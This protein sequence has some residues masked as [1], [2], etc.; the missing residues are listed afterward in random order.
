MSIL[1]SKEKL[2][3]VILDPREKT[4]M[5]PNNKRT[6]LFIIVLQILLG[7][8]QPIL[9]E[10]WPTRL[11]DKHRSGVT[12]ES[13]TVPLT[14][15]WTYKTSTQPE[16]AWTESPA[17]HDYYHLWY[18]LKPRQSFDFSFDVA[19]ADNR[20]YFGS[21][22]TGEVT[23]LNAATGMEDWTF[24]TEGPV[25][26]CPHFDNGK[27]FI[28]S[29]DGYAYCLNASDGSLVWSERAGPTD[30]MIWGNEHMISVWPVRGSVM[31]DGADVFWTVGI[32][33]QEG[34][35]V[36]KRNASDGTGGWAVNASL[37]PQGY[38]L[39][40]AANLF[41]PTGKTYPTVYS[42]SS[43]SYVGTV[44][45]NTR[46]GGSWALL[47]PDESEFWTGPSVTNTTN[48]FNASS[49]AHIASVSGANYL[50]ADSTHSWYNTDSKI[51]K[52]KRSDRSVVWAI[53][54]AYPHALIKAGDTVFAGGFKEIAAFDTDGTRIWTAQ[55]DGKVYG[56]A[57]ANGSLYASTDRG[58][59][60]C[61]NSTIPQIT[62]NQG[63]TDVTTGSAALNGYLESQGGSETT[64]RV[65]WG[66]SD[67]GTNIGI[68]QNSR[69]LGVKSPGPISIDA[70]SL[71][72][73]ALYYYR[74]LATNSYGAVWAPSSDSFI[75]GPVT[76]QA[77]DNSASETGLDTGTFT[78]YRP[79]Q[80]TGEPL[81]V[82]YTVSGT[83]GAGSDYQ[84]LSG[85]V[86]IQQG[87]TS[88]DIVVTP[89]QDLAMN[90]PDETVIVTLSSGGYVIGAPAADTVNIS[91]NSSVS[92]WTNMMKI[93]F[94]G[95]D[96]PSAL[97][98]FPVLVILNENIDNFSYSQF[99][100][101]SG[102]DLLFLNAEQTQFLSYE[103]ETWD[104]SGNSYVWVKV[105]RI[106]SSSD[107]IFAL[108]GNPDETTAP[109]YTSDGSTWSNGFANVWHLKETS[110]IHRDSTTGGNDGTPENGVI[111]NT[112]GIIGGADEFDG[113]NDQITLSSNLTVGSLSNTISSWVKIPTVGSGGLSSG[114]R[115]GI[116]L[117][118]YNS[119]PNCNWE[120]HDDGQMRTYW[121]DGGVSLYGTTDLRDNIWHNI[122]WVRDKAANRSYMYID[123]SLEKTIT[124]AGSDVVFNSTHKIGADNR[125]SSAPNYHG[126]LD[127]I[128]VSGVARSQD[129]LWASY[130]SQMNNSAFMIYGE[131]L[132]S[133]D[134][135]IAY[136][137]FD[138]DMTNVQ[139]NSDL[140]GAGVGNAAVSNED[141]ATGTGALKI[142]DTS[143]SHYMDIASTVMLGDVATVNTVVAWYKYENID[144]LTSD[145]RNF[146]WETAPANYSLSFGVSS[147]TTDGRRRA[148]WYYQGS[149]GGQNSNLS[150]G[151]IVDDGQWHHVAMVW[152]KTSGR[153]KFYHDGSIA[154]SDGDVPITFEELN[155]NPTGFHIGSHR[156][157]DGTRNWDG[158][159]DEVAVFDVELTS[160]QIQALFDKEIG[161][162]PVN[163]GNVLVLIP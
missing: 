127:E 148:Q 61:F 58:S 40:T 121:N 110:G 70:D 53:D 51:Y 111:T 41:V 64:V 49:R 1:N 108:W 79:A 38:L 143:G 54:Y 138:A 152:N 52:L 36:C 132:T 135:L 101:Q 10:D 155:P 48:Q 20:V 34:M 96:R 140:D 74:Y 120:L 136:W 73:S 77:T 18:D 71:A 75:T 118:N 45:V 65:F 62:N 85:S 4:F 88:A 116:L 11:H 89:I 59:I 144:G 30:E 28:G 24:F 23:S 156:A 37:P 33:P 124:S 60:Y 130:Q 97:I 82:H 157:G 122:A 137:N 42:R 119:S 8:C 57:V 94:Q 145:V 50:I 162:Q 106:A 117:G 83:A 149:T 163:P 22:K 107:Y 109:P 35:Y 103:I 160:S 139:G 141:V 32:F 9:A 69:D 158:F 56:L 93:R 147:D 21:S 133:P 87:S 80:T 27:V 47:T 15:A 5:K 16:P 114:E 44:T 12:S 113:D 102:G 128:R 17:Q 134:N 112:T 84:L 129:W 46:D 78:V 14:R 151:P 91:D 2:K 76:I 68:W 104:T 39:A 100:S 153:I 55:V 142:D 90:E 98:D 63:A 26:F 123:G 95:Y 31:V 19:V 126:K 13:L 7:I 92:G 3:S 43:G 159:I 105:P 125:G 154:P 161:G 67:G 6:F 86:V 131:E 81:E 99:A 25:R 29:D 66:T 72:A 146:V 115:V 150:N